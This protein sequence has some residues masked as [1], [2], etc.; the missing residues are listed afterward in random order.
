MLK[1]V[2]LNIFVES[3][4]LLN[5]TNEEPIILEKNYVMSHDFDSVHKDEKLS[6][7]ARS[8]LET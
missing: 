2:P 5:C 1:T 3:M 7:S 6:D 8:G 4:L